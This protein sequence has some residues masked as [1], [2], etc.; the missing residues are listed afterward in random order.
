[1]GQ[2]QGLKG[3]HLTVKLCTRRKSNVVKALLQQSDRLTSI[4]ETGGK[5][6]TNAQGKYRHRNMNFILVDIPVHF[7]YETLRRK[8]LAGISV[9]RESGLQ[10]LW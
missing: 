7:S 10:S 9:L 8:K 4:R 2:T 6:V 3:P 5:T 1:M